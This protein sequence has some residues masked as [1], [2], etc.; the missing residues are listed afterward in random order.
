MPVEWQLSEYHPEAKARWE[1][2]KCKVAACPVGFM[3]LSLETWHELVC[4]Q[5]CPLFGVGHGR[6][7]GRLRWFILV[8]V[9]GQ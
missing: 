3:Q 1:L 9:A 4:E 6:L 5:A 2:V 8:R 7:L